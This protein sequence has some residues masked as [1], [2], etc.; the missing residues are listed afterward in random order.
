M[1]LVEGRLTAV[2][3]ASGLVDS[4]NP[5]IPEGPAPGAVRPHSRGLESTWLGPTDLM[6]TDEAQR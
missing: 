4:E 1:G 3:K 5:G 2:P 6:C